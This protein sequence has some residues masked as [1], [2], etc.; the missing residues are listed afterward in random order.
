[1]N[2]YKI[3]G[4]KVTDEVVRIFEENSIKVMTIKDMRDVINKII[5]VG[6]FYFL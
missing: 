6:I 5:I 2:R 4:T 1:M 3:K